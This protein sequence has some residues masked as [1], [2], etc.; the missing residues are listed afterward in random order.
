MYSDPHICAYIYSTILIDS[1]YRPWCW[2]ILLIWVSFGSLIQQVLSLSRIVKPAVSH[3]ASETKVYPNSG[4]YNTS[5]NVTD[6]LSLPLGMSIF[7]CPTPVTKKI[8][9]S[10]T[11]TALGSL[12][13]K[14]V[15]LPQFGD[16]WA[17]APESYIVIWLATSSSIVFDKTLLLF[18][19]WAHICS[20][21]DDQS[22]A[23]GP[24]LSGGAYMLIILSIPVVI[25]FV[26]LLVLS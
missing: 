22:G 14:S 7:R 20:P 25:M 11:F 9:L 1:I 13:L 24:G 3:L 15:N 12:D 8:V 4:Q 21:R 16:M 18:E 23:K 26:S 6:M 19:K 17:E 5:F 10:A 2:G